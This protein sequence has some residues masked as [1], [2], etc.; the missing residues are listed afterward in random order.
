MLATRLANGELA[1]KWTGVRLHADSWSVI[2]D[3]NRWQLV[4]VSPAGPQG[5]VSFDLDGANPVVKVEYAH[6]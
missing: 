6:E 5:W 1:K 3:G 2:R 4:K